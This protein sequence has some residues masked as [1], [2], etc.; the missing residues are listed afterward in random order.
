MITQGMECQNSKRRSGLKQEQ[1]TQ[2]K[3]LAEQTPA[4]VAWVDRDM[5]YL[6]ATKR[7]L[8]DNGLRDTDIIGKSHY[9][10]F[11][12]TST[13]WKQIYQRCLAGAVEACDRELFTQANGIRNWVKWEIRPWHDSAGEIGG[14]ILCTEIVTER[15]Q[16]EGEL[17]RAYEELE[18]SV[19]E[20][21]DQLALINASLKAEIAKRQRAEEEIYL[22]QTITQAI[23]KAPDLHSSLLLALCKVCEV[24]GWNFAE[25]WI[26]NSAQ[27]VLELSS[28]YYTSSPSLEKFR[29]LSEG[30]T[31]A[32]SIGIPGRVWISKQPE[33][34]HD[35]SQQ[36]N[37]VFFRRNIVLS[38]NL[39]AA[40]GVPIVVDE[41]VLAVFVFFK[42][43]S[44][45]KDKQLVALV[46]SVANQLGLVIQRKRTEESLKESEQRFRAIFNQAAVG[47][48]RVGLDG[49]WLVV[50]Q[51]LCDIVG[52]SREELLERTFQEV[53]H[54]D[55]LNANLECYRRMLV[56]KAQTC[57]LQKRY[58][59][60]DGSHVWVNLTVSVVK[61]PAS[62]QK[63]F[64]TV[65]EDIS[66]RRRAQEELQCSQAMLQLVIDNIPQL[67]FWKDRNSVYQ[68]CNR[69]FALVAGLSK[70][71]EIA[72]KTDYD[73]PWRKSQADWFRQWDARVMETNKPEYRVIEIQP[74]V[75]GKQIWAH[76]NKIPLHDPQG[77]VVGVLGTSLD[78]TERKQAEKA[79]QHSEEQL[80][81]ALRASRMGSWDWNVLSNRV[82]WSDTL[83]LIFG[84]APG[85]FEG[86]FE[87]FLKCVHP[88]DCEFVT[89]LV[90]DTLEQK[91]EREIDYEYRVVWSDGTVHWIAAKGQCFYD[92]M[93][94]PIR[95]IGICLDITERKQTEQ[96]LR[97]ALQKLSFHVENSPLA[98]ME[99]NHEFRLQRW[100]QQAE[101][102]FGWKA[103]EVLG[104]DWQNLQFVFEED[105]KALNAQ[106]CRL[107]DGSQPSNVCCHPNNTKSGAVI[108]CEWYNSALFD[109]S[110]RLVS[111]LSLVQDITERKRAEQ[112]IKQLNAE[113]E[114]RV[115]ERTAQ[116]EA[117][118]KELEAFSY[119]VSHDL[120]APL[121]S[122]DGFSQALLEW[123]SEQ[124]DE[125]GKHYLQRICANSKKM[126][127]LI[128][129]LL[130]L[131][132]VTCSEMYC[133]SIN[134]SAIVQAIAAELQEIQPERNTEFVIE[135]GLFVRGDERLLRILLENLLRNAWK[136]TSKHSQARIEFGTLQQDGQLAYFIRDDGA[137]FDM[138]YADKLFGA[139]Q[140]LHGNTDF[141][142]TGVG[143]ATCAR[144]VRRH[145]GKIWAVAALEEGATFYFTLA[146]QPSLKMLEINT[147]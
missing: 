21:T 117:A 107:M 57:S 135:E 108:D 14:L 19:R 91:K 66:D 147:E 76:T 114:Y 2:Y 37:S 47:I 128:D 83:E 50:N 31:L 133:Q 144:I 77:N 44:C 132:R 13:R 61:Q 129:S 100:S 88:E 1:L 49:Q 80:R 126:E 102:I 89:Q 52:Y 96:A 30:L 36:P 92:E 146:E 9:E 127:Q 87:D 106:T 45:K 16:A 62:E 85:S 130:A 99:W 68:G 11:S 95:M 27:E 81:L 67:I 122:I 35:V 105:C 54:P 145:G 12:E 97:D 53:T 86:S 60:K 39:K 75:N 38:V 94:Q 51:K 90:A 104:K 40:L 56:G 93:G 138:T 32:P 131:S 59:R 63:Y 17:R 111:V 118:N 125:Q 15:Q 58:L 42:F 101:T 69:Q 112:G 82:T 41:Q 119:S 70:P 43:E 26:P 115:A 98:V 20:R 136:Y 139:F 72:G 123:H 109:E 73:L 84:L 140:R 120:R 141:P 25:V 7:W 116:L 65:V 71:E 110:G 55:D 64:I 33:W 79:L 28:A 34:V 5:R 124:L 74:Q 23:S 46:A 78:I 103:E 24:T 22:L 4:A 121:Q 29:Q 137:G 8:T 3:L 134:L 113:L 142:G 6:L 48:G 143:L 10:V 18:I